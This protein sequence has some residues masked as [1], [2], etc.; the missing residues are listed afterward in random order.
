M[1]NFVES[2]S[3]LHIR[4]YSS[5]SRAFLMLLGFK[6]L[7]FYSFCRT[8]TEKEINIIRSSHSFIWSNNQTFEI[9]IKIWTLIYEIKTI[10]YFSAKVADKRQWRNRLYWKIRL[11]GIHPSFAA[12]YAIFC[13]IWAISCL[14]IGRHI[15]FAVKWAI[16]FIF[17]TL[18]NCRKQFGMLRNTQSYFHTNFILINFQ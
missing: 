2:C 3:L 9:N 13:W 15:I 17:L 10:A 4:N 1:N 5:A 7:E 16:F 18:E 8:S 14:L 12:K 6:S 11:F